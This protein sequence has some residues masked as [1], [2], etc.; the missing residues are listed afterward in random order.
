M[1]VQKELKDFLNR[2]QTVGWMIVLM[3]GGFLLQL[4]IL[5]VFAVMDKKASYESLMFSLALP[6]SLKSWLS[7]PWSIIT[8][9][10]FMV[11]ID[12]LRLLV[13]GLIL[14]AFGRIHQQLLGEQRT[15]RLVILAV[16]VIGLVTIIFSSLLSLDTAVP[17]ASNADVSV[18]ST[19]PAQ[20]HDVLAAA[21]PNSALNTNLFHV[22]G[23]LPLI[24]VLVISSITTVP[25][26]PIQ[27]F[28]FGQVKIVWVGIALLGIELVWAGFFTPLGIALMAA[29]LMGFL[30]VYG[31]RRG[32]DI[33][34]IIWSYYQD[35]KPKSQSKSQAKTQ[36][37]VSYS[38]ARETQRAGGA[39]T[40]RKSSVSQ[41]V[42]DD[43]LDKINAKG[44][45]SLTREEKEILFKASSQ[46]EDE[47]KE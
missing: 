14:Y 41:E 32:W 3:A 24:M 20:T 36:M 1:D 34:D 5:T 18:H 39:K 42:I 29:A 45:E 38:A 17:P 25:G 16:P 9:P 28:L 46:K 37:T 6:Y 4:L 8:W 31:T 33:T 23:L 15:R 2:H 7:Q 26:Y 13:N 47:K 11:R 43:I 27:L 21:L 10:L 40:D 30:Y 19:I 35:S 12:V 22:S 44:Y